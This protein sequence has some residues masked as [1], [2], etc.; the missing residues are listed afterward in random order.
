MPFLYELK[1]TISSVSNVI[2]NLFSRLDINVIWPI[3][4]HSSIDWYFKLSTFI[5]EF[6]KSKPGNRMFI[7]TFDQITNYIFTETENQIV[8]EKT[9][10]DIKNWLLQNWPKI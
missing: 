1:S 7:K 10:I 5:F 3:E 4:S 9:D 2:L 8:E 6:G